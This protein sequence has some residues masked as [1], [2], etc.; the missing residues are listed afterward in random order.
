MQWMKIALEQAKIAFDACEVPVGAILVLNNEV[1]AKAY[2]QVEMLQDATAHAEILCLQKAAKS[3]GNWRLNDAIMYCTL[4]PCVMCA[5]AMINSR[6]GGL[7]W[8]APDLR[9][10]AHGSWKNLF[11]Q[12]H[13]I[14]TFPVTGNVLAKECGGLMRRFFQQRRRECLMK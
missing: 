9:Q 12:S 2:N 10:G 1:I 3:V 11:D 4:E 14:H 5:G 7:V 13:P 6:I 8:G